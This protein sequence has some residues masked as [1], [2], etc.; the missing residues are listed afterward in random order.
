MRPSVACVPNSV[1][2]LRR[3]LRPLYTTFQK[4]HYMHYMHYMPLHATTCHYMPLHALHAPHALHATHTHIHTYTLIY[5][6]TTCHTHCT[7]HTEQYST[8]NH[9]LPICHFFD[10]LPILAN[11]PIFTRPKILLATCNLHLPNPA[12]CFTS[13]NILQASIFYSPNILQI[14]NIY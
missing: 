14:L 4:H 3:R 1:P 2:R 13:L 10:S 5:F 12:S 7:L 9:I 11:L 8:R 6:C